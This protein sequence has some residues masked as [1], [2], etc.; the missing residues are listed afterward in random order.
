MN[1]DLP[2]DFKGK[3]GEFFLYNNILKISKGELFRKLMVRLTYEIKGDE[4][5]FYC[6][7][8]FTRE[9]IRTVDHIYP[10]MWGGPTITNNLVPCCDKCNYEKGNLNERQYKKLLNSIQEGTYEKSLKEIQELQNYLTKS[11]T[12]GIPDN[13]LSKKDVSDIIIPRGIGK[14]YYRKSKKYKKVKVYFETNGYIQQPII[15]DRCSTLLDGFY[16]LMFAI[17]N[18]ISQ[19]LAVQ[20]DNVERVIK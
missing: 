2:K 10:K 13:W 20:L 18:D 15:T 7:K 5:C 1:I 9:K 12:F 14:E 3:S 8:K 19:V 11:K 6:N 16:S 17:D 4:R